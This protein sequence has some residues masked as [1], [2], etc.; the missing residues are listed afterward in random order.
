MSVRVTVQ[1]LQ[2]QLPELLDRAVQSGEE[3]IVQRDGED[4]AVILGARDWWRQRS[5]EVLTPPA[6]VTA[7]E[8]ESRSHQIGKRLDALGP[9]YRLSAERQERM[10]ALLAKQEIA[11]LSPTERRE[12]EALVEECD[13]IMLRRAQALPRIG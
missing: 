2:E 10:E 5:E 7:D 3:Y 12:L 1:Q 4:Y 6:A 13:A 9:E 11:P 8:E